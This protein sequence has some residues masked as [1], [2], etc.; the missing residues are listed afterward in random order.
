MALRREAIAAMSNRKWYEEGIAIE[1]MYSAP[2]PSPIL[3]R[4]YLGGIM[5]TLGGSHGPTFIYLPIV[6]LDDCHL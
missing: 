3:Q 2:N 6:Y 5:D 4:D 1:L